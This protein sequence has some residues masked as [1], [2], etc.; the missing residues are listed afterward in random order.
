MRFSALG[1]IL[2]SAVAAAKTTMI[3]LETAEGSRGVEATLDDCFDIDEY[4]VLTLAI[5][6]KCRVFTGVMCTGRTIVLEPGDH[7]VEE[8]VPIGSVICEEPE[9]LKMEL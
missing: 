4:E 8:P 6:K 9:V 5:K 7:S 3:G 2:F 1:L